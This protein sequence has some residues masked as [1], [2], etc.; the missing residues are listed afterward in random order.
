MN[1]DKNLSEDESK[2]EA[3]TSKLLDNAK[4]SLYTYEFDLALKFCERALQIEPSNIETLDLQGSTYTEMG[5]FENAKKVCK[6][7]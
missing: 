2:K 4:H 3:T 7:N 1:K 5:D 6:D